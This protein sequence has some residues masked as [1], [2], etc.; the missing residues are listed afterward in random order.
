MSNIHWQMAGAMI[1]VAPLVVAFF[2]FQRQFIQGIA[3]SGL[4][5]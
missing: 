3:L 1:A 2:L 5:Q 4:K